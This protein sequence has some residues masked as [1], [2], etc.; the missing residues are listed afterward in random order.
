MYYDLKMKEQE[1]QDYLARIQTLPEKFT[2]YK[3]KNNLPSMG[4]LSMLNNL[5]NQT[6]EEI[7]L[8]YKSRAEIEQFFDCYKNT[9]SATATYMQNDDAPQGWVFVTT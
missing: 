5:E 8:T 9:L 7:Y 3:Y 2:I 4:T 6:P 1:K